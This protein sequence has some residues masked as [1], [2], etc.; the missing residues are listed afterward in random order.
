MKKEIGCGTENNFLGESEITVTI[1]LAEYRNLVAFKAQYEG[2][3]NK[4][5]LQIFEKNKEI[6]K[7]KEALLANRTITE[8]VSY[9]T[10]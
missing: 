9:V 5:A 7:L 6:D 1:T 8:E 2:E 4:K 3:I 10:E